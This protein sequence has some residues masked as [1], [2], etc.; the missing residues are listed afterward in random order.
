[1]TFGMRS[2]RN[3]LLLFVLAAIIGGCAAA[4][5]DVQ[6][7]FTSNDSGIEG[8]LVATT[9]TDGRVEVTGAARGTVNVATADKTRQV[10]TG[11]TDSNGSFEILL[12]PGNYFVYTEPVDGML[13][14]RT[15]AVTP[16]QITSLELRLPPQ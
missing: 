13:Y 7:G 2:S 4:G 10:A 6:P 11:D 15:V 14:G 16:R 12:R 8:R 5:Y 1:M 3:L 9:S